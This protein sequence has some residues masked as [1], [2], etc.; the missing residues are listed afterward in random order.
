MALYMLSMF[1]PQDSASVPDDLPEI[2]W[3]ETHCPTTVYVIR[4]SRT[5][6]LAAFMEIFVTRK[7]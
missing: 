1:Y 7:L 2:I 5:G 6:T 3:Q 4:E